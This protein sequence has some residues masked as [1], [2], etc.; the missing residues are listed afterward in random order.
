DISIPPDAGP[1]IA[2]GPIMDRQP[3]QCEPIQ[4]RRGT[5]VP[6]IHGSFLRAGAAFLGSQPH[7]ADDPAGWIGSSYPAGDG[8]AFEVGRAVADF[9]RRP[10]RTGGISIITLPD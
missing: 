1:H 9:A 6:N 5:V 8:S 7:R 2:F 3:V 10:A 4:S